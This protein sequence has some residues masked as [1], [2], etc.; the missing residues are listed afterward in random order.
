M[1]MD[2]DV[3]VVVIG[4]GLAGLA[5]ATR[6]HDASISVA[7]LEAADA[8]GGRVRTD[9]VDGFQ[10]DRG[11]QVLLPGY[12]EV[13]RVMD[14]EALS[15]GAFPPAVTVQRGARTWTLADPF[16]QPSAVLSSVR[17]VTGAV[18]S[19]SDAI[20]MLAWRH[21]L[22]RSPGSQIAHRPQV[23]LRQ[24]LAERGFSSRARDRFFAPFFAGVLFD[25][26]LSTSSRVAELIL[27]SFFRGGAAL[28]AAG[29]GA[30]PAQLAARLPDGAVTVA[31]PVRHLTVEHAGVR[32][33]TDQMTVTAR[34]VVVATDGPSAAHLLADATPAYPQ[35]QI[36]EEG[37][38]A[39]TLWFAT[40][41]ASAPHA[42]LV[43][44][45]DPKGLSGTAGAQIA[46]VA[47]V[48][49]VADRYAPAGQHLVAVTFPSVVDLDDAAL[50]E[51]VR[52]RL[53]AWVDGDVA[54]WRRLRVDRI[55]WAQPRQL[56]ED[57]PTLARSVQVSPTV[58]I[59]GDHRDTGT[60][61]GSLVSGRRAATALLEAMT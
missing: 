46:T 47:T 55:A 36:R 58:W 34:A 52:G 28:P 4:A 7:V 49:A 19:P 39:T 61:Q 25:P 60:I 35:V 48:S 50:D 38:G 11:F 2:H 10:L 51:A 37:R 15:L 21:D 24:R 13:P 1:A 23:S 8:V 53:A 30:L 26:D 56:P 12:P 33:M 32:V 27:R 5:C 29:M 57:L 17:A 16:Q 9:H 31:A 22:L 44:S 41:K 59:C 18:M 40:P 20:R 54:S 6:L 43:I 42:P 14:L 45:A 3:D